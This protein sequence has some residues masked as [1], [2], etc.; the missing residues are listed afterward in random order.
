MPTIRLATP[1]D[2]AAVA[3]IYAPVVTS[4]A[5]SFELEAPDAAEMSRR[6][7]G[8]LARYPFLVCEAGGEVL[9]YAYG[10]RHRSRAAYDWSVE[11][12]VYVNA[13]A[14]K[15][16]VGR[17]LYRSL[18]ALLALQGFHAAYAGI[19]LPNPASVGLHEALGFRPVGV[20]GEIGYKLG[21]WHD[22]GWWQR[23]LT[24]ASGS[25]AA[26]VP[27]PDL[28]GAAGWEEAL[29]AGLP[30]LRL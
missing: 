10:S 21:A 13:S 18:L 4:T 22:V 1:E 5:T 26:P 7:L 6:I 28:V 3:A 2:A 24:P 9:G 11:V 29:A 16:G 20:F 15:L 8:T 14:R 30:S 25:P 12:S 23:R 19:A 27:L 17:A